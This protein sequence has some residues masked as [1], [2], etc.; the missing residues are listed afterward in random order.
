[1]NPYRVLSRENLEA[2][3]TKRG[4][5]K[6]ETRTSTGT[7]WRSSQSGKHL[8]VPDAYEGMYPDFILRGL[9]DQMEKM[10]QAPIH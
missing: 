7:F 8:Q 2:E 1:M 6:T 10:G 3:L 5:S 9:N 4:F